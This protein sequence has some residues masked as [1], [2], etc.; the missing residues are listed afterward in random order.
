MSR[1]LTSSTALLCLTE[2][3][4]SIKL[5]VSRDHP[6]AGLE[7]RAGQSP[8]SQE[9][10]HSSDASP[11][12]QVASERQDEKRYLSRRELR[13]HFPVSGMTIWRWTRDPE[14]AFPRP[15]KLGRNGRNFWWLPEILEWERKRAESTSSGPA[16]KGAR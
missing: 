11:G 7:T 10:R 12:L 16:P 6:P 8:A 3:R 14:V 13:A 15:R 4:S 5:A 9:E 2:P 1:S